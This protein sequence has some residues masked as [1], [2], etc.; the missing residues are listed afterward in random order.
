M[1]P[2]EFNAMTDEEVTAA[3]ASSAKETVEDPPITGPA[4]GPK[5]VTVS[6]NGDRSTVRL[7][8]TSN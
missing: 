1:I 2:S 5:A 8:A 6:D 7:S 3:L 4:T